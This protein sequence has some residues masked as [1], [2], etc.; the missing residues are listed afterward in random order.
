MLWD[1]AIVFGIGLSQLFLTIYAV[2][3][4]V[5]EDKLKIA[6]IMAVVGALGLALTVYGAIRSV[7]AQQKL[8]AD[9][10]ELKTRSF[11]DIG[12]TEFAVDADTH[13]ATYGITFVNVFCPNVGAK[14][15]WL[16][17]CGAMVFIDDSSPIDFKEDKT[18][19]EQYFQ[20][21]IAEY[22]EQSPPQSLIPG[23]WRWGSSAG[24]ASTKPLIDALNNNAKTL[25]VVGQVTYK[26]RDNE[27]DITRKT[28]MCEF[29][30][31]PVMSRPTV[32]HACRVHSGE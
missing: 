2:W 20:A 8:E 32:W 23:R 31:P 27:A 17:S 24:P 10:A 7:G 19:Q 13:S 9:I 30:Q 5:T 12:P 3:V 4:S 16:I 22:K 1:I 11:V 18:R 28:D 29:M 14:I 6:F 25:V 21:F 15:A 26:D